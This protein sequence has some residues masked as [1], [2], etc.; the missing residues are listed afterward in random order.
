MRYYVDMYQSFS[1]K[2]SL[3]KNMEGLLVAIIQVVPQSRRF[4]SLA[5][6][7]PRSIK[8]QKH[9][10]RLAMYANKWESRREGMKCHFSHR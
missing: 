6:G 4:F 5:Y 2:K 9:T 3:P 8:I 10:V 7:G 1:K